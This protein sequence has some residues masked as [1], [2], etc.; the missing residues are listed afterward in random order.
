LGCLLVQRGRQPLDQVE[1]AD[2][3][4]AFTHLATRL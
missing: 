3:P 1:F 2:L 4:N